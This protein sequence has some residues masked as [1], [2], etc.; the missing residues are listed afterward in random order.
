MNTH[1]TIGA[2][3]IFLAACGA[4]S[5]LNPGDANPLFETREVVLPAAKHQT[6]LAGSFDGI[7]HLDITHYVN[8]DVLIQHSSATEQGRLIIL[9]AS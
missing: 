5:N 3:A 2:P 7:P 8:G 9:M 6:V 4:T 1:W